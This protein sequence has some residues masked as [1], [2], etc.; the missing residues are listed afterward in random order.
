MEERKEEKKKKRKEEKKKEEGVREEDVEDG[1]DE[2]HC[3]CEDGE[4]EVRRQHHL[5][6]Q[7]QGQVCNILDGEACG[8]A[9]AIVFSN[10]PLP[11]CLKFIPTTFYLH[12]HWKIFH[13]MLRD[14][15]LIWLSISGLI[16]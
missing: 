10:F 6:L 11:H 7:L 5:S 15:C 12:K 4:D 16:L 9:L 3:A 13:C 1:A 8:R 14:I 2:V